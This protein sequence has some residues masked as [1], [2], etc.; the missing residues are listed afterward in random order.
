MDRN[1]NSKY[2]FVRQVRK[3]GKMFKITIPQNIQPGEYVLVKKVDP[4]DVADVF[5][6]FLLRSKK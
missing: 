2:P 4:N 1:P 3:E 6:K 5:N